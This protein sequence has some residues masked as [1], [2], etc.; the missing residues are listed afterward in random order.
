MSP[1]EVVEQGFEPVSPAPKSAFNHHTL[2]WVGYLLL[3]GSLENSEKHKEKKST[4]CPTTHFSVFPLCV[5]VCV[6]TRKHLT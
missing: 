6:C 1:Q 5:C 2:Q 3:V 4:H